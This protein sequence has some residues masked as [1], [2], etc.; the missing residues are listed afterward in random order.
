[1]HFVI[2]EEISTGRNVISVQH[3]QVT[4]RPVCDRSFIS[5]IDTAQSQQLSSTVWP[6]INPNYRQIIGL[7]SGRANVDSAVMLTS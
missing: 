2:Q 5:K 4:S 7:G 6:S 3:Q 1:M